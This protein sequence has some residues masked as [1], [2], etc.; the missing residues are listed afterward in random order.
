MNDSQLH[1]G[2]MRVSLTEET[3]ILRLEQGKTK[4]FPIPN[5]TPQRIKTLK[6]RKSV[7]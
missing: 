7:V 4:T 1:T 3:N 2:G 6:D 5:E